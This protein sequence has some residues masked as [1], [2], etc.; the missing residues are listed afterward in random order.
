MA[1]STLT[2]ISQRLAVPIRYH[3]TPTLLTADPPGAAR[4]I[5]LSPAIT[6]AYAIAIALD[7]R[8]EADAFAVRWEVYCRELGYEPVDSFPAHGEYDDEDQRALQVVAYHRASARAV[9]CFRLVLADPR[10]PTAP[11]HIEKVCGGLPPEAFP[12]T[13]DGRLGCVELSRFCIVGSHRRHDAA[14]AP[15]DGVDGQRWR[16]EAPQRRGL[17]AL[18]WLTAAAIVVRAGLDHLY[19]LMDPRLEFLSRAMGMSFTAVGPG[20]QFRGV[21]LPYRTGRRDLQAMLQAYR[22]PAIAS[23]LDA[24]ATAALRHPALAPYLPDGG[25]G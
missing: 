11:F 7:D 2:P 18:L 14:D 9:G 10:D 20:V 17:P 12:G 19:A 4:R 15:P 6:D 5:P 25:G 21:R 1:T 13:A 22:S 3:R 24:T 16:A 8:V 23:L